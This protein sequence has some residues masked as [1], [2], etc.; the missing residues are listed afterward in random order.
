MKFFAPFLMVLILAGCAP[1]EEEVEMTPDFNDFV[2][3]VALAWNDSWAAGS[4]EA[5]GSF[6][7]Q[8]A[9]MLPP[10]SGPVVGRDSIQA[11]YARDMAMAPGGGITMI[12]A[13][14]DGEYGYERGTYTVA[15]AEGEQLDEGKYLAVWRLV[16]GEWKI[17]RD[18]FNSSVPESMPEM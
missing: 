7:A 17:Y 14:A 10:G 6:Y 2:K 16:D 9:I 15:T 3:G 12:E 8:D 1:Q 11:H 4:A 13:F 18:I 5:I